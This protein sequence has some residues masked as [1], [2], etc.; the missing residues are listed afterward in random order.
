MA[1]K[2][3]AELTAASWKE[4][5]KAEFPTLAAAREWA[6]SHGTTADRCIVKTATGQPVALH[7]RGS[8][9][10]GT[11][12]YKALVA[13]DPGPSYRPAP[14]PI[15]VVVNMT[16]FGFHSV[17]STAPVVV[18]AIDENDFWNKTLKGVI[19]PKEVDAAFEVARVITDGE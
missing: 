11:N 14:R 6:A 18:L 8:V 17:L 7:V 19:D 13:G 12:W 3:Y 10:D 2:Y 9:G 4:G 15:R 5:V 1:R 16:G